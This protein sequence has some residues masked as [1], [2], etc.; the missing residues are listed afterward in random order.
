MKKFHFI[1][2]LTSYGFS[3]KILNILFPTLSAHRLY[4]VFYTKFH[5][6]Q[7]NELYALIQVICLHPYPINIVSDSIYSV[8]VLKKYRNLHCKLLVLLKQTM[9]LPIFLD[10][11]NNFY[12]LFLLNILQVFL[13]IH[14]DDIV[15]QTYH[16]LKLQR[17]K[18]KRGEYT[19]ILLSSLSKADFT[20][21]QHKIFSK[22]VTIVNSFICF[23]FFKLA[24]R[25][26]LDKSR[27]TF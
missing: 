23:K 3:L 18:L 6:A 9:A 26:C 21:F 5:S 7:Q 16:T 22:P 25:R 11:L 4:K 14:R 19:G 15:E 10:T 13:I 2:Y 27:K 1:I 12:N 8:F 20:R 24:T 17:K